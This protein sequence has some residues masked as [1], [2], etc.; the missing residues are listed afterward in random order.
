MRL[1]EVV[2]RHRIKFI[3]EFG[4]LYYLFHINIIITVTNSLFGVILIFIVAETKV[5]H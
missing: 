2:I 4:C 3:S 1:H 5:C